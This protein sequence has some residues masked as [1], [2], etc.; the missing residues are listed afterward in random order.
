MALIIALLFFIT[1]GNVYPGGKQQEQ[2]QT[3]QDP[4]VESQ[5]SQTPTQI[6]TDNKNEQLA[7]V[8][9][10]RVT[11]TRA[12]TVTKALATAYPHRISKAEFRDGDWAVLIY[13]TW[14]YFADGKFLPEELRASAD[15][16]NPQTFYN[17]P[18]E[19][20][21]WKAPSQEEAARYKE[22]AKNRNR[23]S[24][25]R[26]TL[27]FDDL[28]RAHN[29]DE[30]FQ[31]I[32]SIRFL[33][34]SVMVHYS[35]LS[36][37]SLVEDKIL[38]LAKTNPHIQTWI[39]SIDTATAWNWRNIA[40]TQSRSFHAYG[41]AIDILPKSL[42]GKETYWLWATRKRL[43]WW[44]VSYKDRYHPPAEVIKAFESYGFIWGGKWLFYD[45]MH[46]E[47]RPELLLL[48]GMEIN[49]IR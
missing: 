34:H 19:L 10:A 23:D 24:V 21:T 30:S 43:E 6:T 26:S 29:K 25:K 9:N 31:R 37:L 7:P 2:V 44:N 16:Y 38:T 15:N 22:M 41:A 11:N 47:Y 35:I 4:P 32:K 36:E 18:A 8:S 3:K 39:K 40:D 42:G 45:T 33:G 5:A 20:P 48:S 12:E 1:A 46:F 49:N 27:F 14:Y 28:W 13:D 17:Y